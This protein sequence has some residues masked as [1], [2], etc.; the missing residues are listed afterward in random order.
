[1][2]WLNFSRII[3]AVRINCNKYSINLRL[4]QYHLNLKNLAYYILSA[5][6]RSIYMPL[7][8]L[9]VV[10]KLMW[11]LHKYR[12]HYFLWC[13]QMCFILYDVHT[14]EVM[15]FSLCYQHF[16][17]PLYHFKQY[18]VILFSDLSLFLYVFCMLYW[19]WTI[20]YREPIILV[21]FNQ[22]NL[23]NLEYSLS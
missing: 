14:T 10:H 12:I 22:R 9:S 18:D 7:G 1:M 13:K 20:V 4:V 3:S 23:F 11:N 16:I 21:E 5:I 6:V 15:L 17:S 8:C 2:Q 19:S